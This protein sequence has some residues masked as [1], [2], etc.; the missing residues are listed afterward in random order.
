[1]TYSIPKKDL[2]PFIKNSA[3]YAEVEK[4]L[5]VIKVAE[6]NTGKNFYVNAIDPFSAVFDALSKKITL[7]D[8]KKVEISRKIQKTMQNALGD[9]HQ[10]ILGHVKGWESLGRGNVCDVFSQNKKI[11]A[12]VKNKYNTTKGNHKVRIYD[13]LKSLTASPYKGFTGYYVE[14]IPKNKGTYDKEFTP[15]DNVTHARRPKNKKIR[16]IDGKSFYTMVT[17]DKDALKKLYNILPKVI[18]YI[19]GKSNNNF[20]QDRLFQ[21][22]FNKTF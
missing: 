17:G 20:I 10:E 14:V 7:S 3:L 16:V 15:S 13:D 18:G 1:M 12:E 6:K 8:W 22:L 5:V 21:E 19:L 9:F 4:V 11:I 2:L